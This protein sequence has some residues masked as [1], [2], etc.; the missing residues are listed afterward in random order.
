MPEI[1]QQAN[2]HIAAID[3]PAVTYLGPKFS[4][5]ELAARTLFP[6]S[7]LMGYPTFTGVMNAIAEDPSLV[8][9]VP[10]RNEA[11]GEV[12]PVLTK[13]RSGL[14]SIMGEAPLLIHLDLAGRGRRISVVNTVFS[15]SQ[16]LEQA[17]GFLAKNLPG[18]EVH[19][20]ESTSK[21]AQMVHE[22]RGSSAAI[23]SPQA[24]IDHKLNILAA[25]IQDRN[26]NF[27][28][29]LIVQS[30]ED[31][32]RP[33]LN[34]QLDRAGSEARVAGIVTPRLT[35]AAGRIAYETFAIN[36]GLEPSIPIYT[37]DQ[38]NS[39]VFHYFIEFTGNPNNL[40]EAF[41]PRNPERSEVMDFKLLGAYPVSDVMYEP[42]ASFK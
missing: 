10:V 5:S 2:E 19:E 12:F 15:H 41:K 16:P 42:P 21:A 7:K 8:G 35:R 34:G 29:F 31:D 3:A 32:R 28:T 36:R 18:V 39:E 4:F 33:H 11:S 38:K 37:K 14:F 23:C 22:K 25:D 13:L 27:T 6:D 1:L 24:A 26:D 40:W 9:V 17:K 30:Y 20:A